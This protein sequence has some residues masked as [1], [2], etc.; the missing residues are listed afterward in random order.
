MAFIGFRVIRVLE[1]WALPGM[2]LGRLVLAGIAKGSGLNLW[3]S[4]RRWRS[5]MSLP[6]VS[7]VGFRALNLRR[8]VFGLLGLLV[9]RLALRPR[10]PNSDSFRWPPMSSFGRLGTS[11]ADLWKPN[12]RMAPVRP[13]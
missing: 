12:T 11:G 13:A 2:G 10:Y 7:R 4:P 8:V 5:L 1:Y 6:C 9:C 3:S